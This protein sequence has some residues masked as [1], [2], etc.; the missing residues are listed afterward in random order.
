[1][2]DDNNEGE[3]ILKRLKAADDEL[4]DAVEDKIERQRA[5]AVWFGELSPSDRRAAQTFIGPKLTKRKLS[6][7]RKA[8]DRGALWEI[9]R[10]TD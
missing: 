4:A 8:D 9:R 3:Q 5:F 6:L 1:M 2:N 7:W 10:I